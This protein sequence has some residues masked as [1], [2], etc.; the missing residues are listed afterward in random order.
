MPDLAPLELT[1]LENVL[2]KSKS[3]L[4][5]KNFYKQVLLSPCSAETDLGNCDDVRDAGRCSRLSCKEAVIPEGSCCP[6]CGNGPII[7]SV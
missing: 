3:Y 6:V 1:T 2:Q 7:Y 4:Y 5:Q